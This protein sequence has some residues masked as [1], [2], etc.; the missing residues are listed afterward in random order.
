M[1]TCS[2]FEVNVV[3]HRGKSSH[4]FVIKYR[5]IKYVERTKKKKHCHISMIGDLEDK[6]QIHTDKMVLPKGLCNL[7]R[8]MCSTRLTTSFVAIS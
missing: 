6:R 1:G 5:A 4:L 3:Q 7:L 8:F 2:A